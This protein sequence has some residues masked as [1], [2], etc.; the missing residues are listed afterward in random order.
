MPTIVVSELSPEVEA[1]FADVQIVALDVEGVDLSRAGN[2]II[3]FDHAATAT[4]LNIF[5]AHNNNNNKRQMRVGSVGS[6]C[7]TFFSSY[8]FSVWCSGQI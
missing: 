2:K 7:F 8:V 6:T 1:A 4:P 5:F 3:V